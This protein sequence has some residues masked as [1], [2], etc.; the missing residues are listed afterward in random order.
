[1]T[2]TWLKPTEVA[3]RL[4]ISRRQAYYL[5]AKGDIPSVQFSPQTTRIDENDLN[6]Y[7]ENRKRQNAATS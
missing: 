7:I 1:M 2:T 5:L 3:K 4:G 6:T